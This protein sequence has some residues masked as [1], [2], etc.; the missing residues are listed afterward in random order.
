[1]ILF[2]GTKR[3]HCLLFTPVNIGQPCC[4]LVN[5]VN[6]N[7]YIKSIT[8]A[9][10]RIFYIKTTGYSVHPQSPRIIFHDMDLVVLMIYIA[11]REVS[12]RRNY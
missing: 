11:C 3:V 10:L 9:S 12:W 5:L 6:T 1:M 2:L 4:T 8:T 7:Y